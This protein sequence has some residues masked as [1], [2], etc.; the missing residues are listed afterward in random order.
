V[1]ACPDGT[2][3]DSSRI[4]QVCDPT[5]CSRCSGP[6]VSECAV[7]SCVTTGQNGQCVAQCSTLTEYR[8][9]V[10]GQYACVACSPQCTTSGAL[11]GCTGAGASACRACRDHAYDGACFSTC[12]G[13]FESGVCVTQCTQTQAVASYIDTN[14]VCQECHSQCLSCTGPAQADCTT[15]RGFSN[16]Q[17]LCVAQCSSTERLVGTQC[18]ACHEQCYG[19]CT[20]PSATECLLQPVL[21]SRGVTTSRRCRGGIISTASGNRT[22]VATCSSTEAYQTVGAT[23]QLDVSGGFLCR[24]CETGFRCV[25][26]Q[27]QEPCPFSTVACATGSSACLACPDSNGHCVF[28]FNKGA[29]DAVQCDSGFTSEPTT[30]DCISSASNAEA[31]STDKSADTNVT[32]LTAVAVGGVAFLAFVAAF[33][34][35]SGKSSSQDMGPH[36]IANPVFVAPSPPQGYHSPYAPPASPYGS[37]GAPAAQHHF[38][39]QDVRGGDTSMM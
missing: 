11:T 15:C 1:S 31:T 23:P 36:S 38:L 6:T 37:H 10:A 7:G 18:V 4:C 8:V 20:G 35:V 5:V 9:G 21:S 24:P 30:C 27:S 19:S 39:Q 26:G 25:D 28:N 29:M 32:M 12:P 17:G 34:Y 22:C 3:A 16:S 2:W 33:V 14:R 13:Y